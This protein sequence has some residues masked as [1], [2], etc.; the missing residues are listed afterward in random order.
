[1]AVLRFVLRQ[2]TADLWA[3]RN[4]ILLA[5]E[6][7]LETDT[8]NRKIGDGVTHWNDLPY[9]GGPKGDQGPQGLRGPQGLLGPKGD[10]GIQGPQ[11]VPGPKG[12]Q[13][14]QGNVGPRGLQGL[15]GIQGPKGD[16]GLPGQTG[17]QGEPGYTGPIG[18]EGPPGD[19]GPAGPPGPKGDPGTQGLKG[20][21]GIQGVAG[22]KGDQGI[23]GVAGP[24]GDQ[25]IQGIPGAKGD[26]GLQGIAGPKGDQG[27]QGVA[28]PKGDQGL[29][30]DP[31]PVGPE[32]P[33]G[34]QG[35]AGTLPPTGIPSRALYVESNGSYGTITVNSYKEF[36]GVG[37]PPADKT[38]TGDIWTKLQVAA[39]AS[40]A[41]SFN[42][43]GASSATTYSYTFPAGAAGPA[44]GDTVVL[45]LF[46][47]TATATVW[48]PATLGA[49]SIDPIQA[50]YI[51]SGFAAGIYVFKAD[52][53]TA[54]S[55]FSVAVSNPTGTV[56][57][58]TPSF[59]CSWFK[60]LKG[61]GTQGTAILDS[62][63]RSAIGSGAIKTNP[64]KVTSIANAVEFG[65]AL[66]QD[67]T[68]PTATQASIVGL[69]EYNE[70]LEGT[71]QQLQVMGANLSPVPAGTTIGNRTFTFALPDNTTPSGPF[72]VAYTFAIEANA[73]LA[74]SRMI[75]DGSAWALLDGNI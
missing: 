31:G 54:G 40:Y 18:P 3:A 50:P 60:G 26:Q 14:I 11:G 42:A 9:A 73:A 58:T 38:L 67:S 55:T 23:Q 36:L 21:Q 16:Q 75:Y 51:T 33:Q 62:V 4:P 5:G 45:S 39:P 25:G 71:P 12:D 70:R 74:P 34:I 8:R 24:K 46:G 37:T 1:V 49:R 28:G 7:G 43:R 53:A 65:M 32:G 22:P 29:Q 59:M 64:T 2:G 69:T 27:I 57:A 30:G 10:Q 63:A 61:S 48:A 66:T 6:E 20:D 13:G 17:P 68:A 44:D 72:G 56:T 47:Y 41:G 19:L 52:A 15:Q 35:P